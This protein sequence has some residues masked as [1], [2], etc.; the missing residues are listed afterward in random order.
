MRLFNYLIIFLIFNTISYSSMKTAY[1]FSFNN[2]NGGKLNLSDYKGKT[3]VITNVASRCGFTNQYEGLQ[4]IWDEY[5]EKNLVVEQFCEGEKVPVL[6]FGSVTFEN[7]RKIMRRFLKNWPKDKKIIIQSGWAQ[8]AIERS[9]NYIF[10]IDRISHDQLFQHASV[11]IHHGGAG[12]TASVLHAGVP[13]IIIPLTSYVRLKH[14]HIS[15]PNVYRICFVYSIFTLKCF[16]IPHQPMIVF[17][18]NS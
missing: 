16:T 14:K 7:T 10:T 9:N 15:I 3:L 4:S 2:I 8:L 17:L 12:T 13:H 1:D 11:V 5:K 18:M 6:T